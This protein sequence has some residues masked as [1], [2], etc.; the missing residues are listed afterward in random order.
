MSKDIEEIIDLND[1]LAEKD[2]EIERLQSIIKELRI[3]FYETF[4][5]KQ[6]GSYTITETDYKDIEEILEKVEENS[7]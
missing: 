6:N 2:K 1:E 7:K 4:R 3:K 5:I